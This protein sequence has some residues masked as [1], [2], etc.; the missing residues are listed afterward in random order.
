MWQIAGTIFIA[1]SLPGRVSV[2][3]FQVKLDPAISYYILLALSK[4]QNALIHEGEMTDSCIASRS[5]Q[6]VQCF[7]RIICAS[8]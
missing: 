2:F 6:S 3:F 1:K 8:V 4:V 7:R 5:T